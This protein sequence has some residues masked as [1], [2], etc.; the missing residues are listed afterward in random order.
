[1][2][3]KEWAGLSL[4]LAMLFL[5]GGCYR[6]LASPASFATLEKEVDALEE[7]LGDSAVKVVA[8]RKALRTQLAETASLNAERLLFFDALKR[9]TR[10]LME[11]IV[12]VF[13]DM[14]RLTVLVR[15]EG[16]KAD[17]HIN[18]ISTAHK[19]SAQDWETRL[20]N[21]RAHFCSIDPKSA[22]CTGA[23]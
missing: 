10:E 13:D 9:K 20:R 4:I 14:S 8:R 7:E 11:D 19:A 21:V 5:V 1:M 16:N 17:G 23:Q 12:Q 18:R 2:V 22:G 3:Q 15:G 6:V